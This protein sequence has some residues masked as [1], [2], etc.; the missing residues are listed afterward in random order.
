MKRWLRRLRGAFKMGLTWGF[1]W[2]AAGMVLML[3]SL[4]VTGSTGADV[5]YPV[6]FG[7]LGF[8]AGIAF[9]GVLVI[10]E[11]RRRFDELSHPRFAG[12]GAVGGLSF[13]VLFVF[14]VAAFAEGATFIQNLVFLG[15]LFAGIGASIASGVLVLARRAEARELLDASA[16]VAEVGLTEDEAREL[17][18]SKD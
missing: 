5:P 1:T 7:A 10:G 18:G 13:S 15:P 3:G 6:G 2:F 4:L 11:G 14:A 8:F 17:L 9:S 12:W 16:D